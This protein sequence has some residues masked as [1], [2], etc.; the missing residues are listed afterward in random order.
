MM[1]AAQ[2]RVLVCHA[3]PDLFKYMQASSFF[4][5]FIY[6]GRRRAAGP[7]KA[8]GAHWIAGSWGSGQRC[9]A[10]S[11]L[12]GFWTVRAKSMSLSKLPHPVCP[13]SDHSKKCRQSKD[14]I[15]DR[16]M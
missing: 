14:K 11:V 13:S 4:L 3:E 1:A 6:R 16:E 7:V 5:P 12:V 15:Y 2:R 10:H 9:Q 8:L